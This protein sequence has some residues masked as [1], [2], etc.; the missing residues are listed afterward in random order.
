MKQGYFITFE[1]GDGS[2]KSTQIKKLK[3]Y[4]QARGHQVT[5]TREPGGTEIG[6]KIRKIILDPASNEMSAMTE[7]LLYAASR[8]QHVAQVIRPALESGHIVICDR[9]IDS[10]MAYQGYGRGLCEA[11]RIINQYA[12]SEC[13]PDLTFLMKLAPRV[14]SSRIEGRK[15]D[16]IELEEDAFHQAVHQGYEELARLYADRIIGID[17]SASIEAVEA[18]I[19]RHMEELLQRR[20]KRLP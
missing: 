1:G 8:A 11:V 7:A 20:A 16:R 18:E 12:V 10:S 6:E 13:M 15:K 9:F 5:L 14:G 19:N 3:T 17:A 4:L 2:G